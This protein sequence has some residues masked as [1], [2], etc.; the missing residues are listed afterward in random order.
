MILEIDNTK[1]NPSPTSLDLTDQ[2]LITL[3]G[4]NGSGKS[5]I[6]E[7]IFNKY[8]LDET[9]KVICFSSGQNESFSKTYIPFF[10]GNISSI[11]S[12][13]WENGNSSLVE[14]FY[15]DIS[16]TRF[17]IFF[18]TTLKPEGHVREYLKSKNYITTSQNGAISEDTSSS[19]EISFRVLRAF[20]GLINSLEEQ[21]AT[22]PNLQSIRKTFIYSSLVRLIEQKI[23]PAYDWDYTI[24]KRNITLNSN[25]IFSIFGTDVSTIFT[26]LTYA[27]HKKKVIDI[28]SCKLNFLDNLEMNDLSDGEYQML[29]TYAILDLFDSENTLFLF[30]EIDSHLYFKNISN[31]WDRLKKVDGRLITTTH[32][33]DSLM[34]NHYDNI[35]LVEDGKIDTTNLANKLLNRLDNFSNEESYKFKLAS[36]IKYFALMENKFDW[37]VFKKL[38]AIKLDTNFNPEVF[39]QVKF[40]KQAAGFNATSEVF[41]NSKINWIENFK[42]VN[43]RDYTT[44]QIF[45]VCDKDELPVGD[46][47]PSN[48]VLVSNALPERKS[49][50]QL[51]SNRQN[52]HL[53]SWKRR[54]IE[55][56]LLSPTMLNFNDTGIL[57]TINGE[58]PRRQPLLV[59]SPN[60]NNH[61]R[62]LNIKSLMHSLYLKDGIQHIGTHEE[63]VDYNKLENIISQ[64][65]RS[66]ISEDIENMYNYILGKIDLT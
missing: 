4:G 19:L 52:A 53:L 50:T 3:I 47:L 17:L 16:W 43:G 25:D 58:L 60:D 62:I 33:A 31:V 30:D 36:K 40:I 56:Y 57:E 29:A 41:G 44:E 42:R 18:S 15:F 61:T 48:G 14:S 51:K 35:R 26:F 12:S 64:I 20:R 59:N 66:E 27:T 5:A 46:I 11:Q 65:P 8:L 6:L 45:M 9:I 28:S 63:G 2:N 22:N 38:A 49:R 10:D 54:E 7:S 13:N 34:L 21:E 23:D 1:C 55:N 32:S 24:T 37:F 39:R